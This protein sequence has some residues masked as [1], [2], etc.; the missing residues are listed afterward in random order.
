MKARRLM[1]VLLASV[2]VA[3]TSLDAQLVESGFQGRLC[4][5]VQIRYLLHLPDGYTTTQNQWPLMLYL[6]GGLGRGDDFAK[7]MWYPVPRMLESG[8][9]SL[10]FIVVIPQCREGEMWTDTEALIALL[11]DICD[12]HAVDPDRIYLVGYSMGGHG[13]WYLA[14]RHPERFAAI[15]PMSGMSNPWWTSRLKGLPVWAFH[16]GQDDRVPSRESEQMIASLGGD[17]DTVR[18]TLNPDRG[19]R[20]PTVQEHLELF[21]WL[22]AQRRNQN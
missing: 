7:L 6:H 19:H 18:F 8:E 10:P 20:P 13:V 15:A 2:P 9:Y 21:Q 16:G 5:D 11:D 4:R 3:G 14:Y 17:H 1:L 22:L 12:A